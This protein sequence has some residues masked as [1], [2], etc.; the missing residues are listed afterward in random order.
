MVDPLCCNAAK[1]GKKNCFHI[2]VMAVY[3]SCIVDLHLYVK[4]ALLQYTCVYRIGLCRYVC[5]YLYHWALA[6]WAMIPKKARWS[7]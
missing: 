1:Q 3:C 2:V 4:Y 5:V 7:S 6:I